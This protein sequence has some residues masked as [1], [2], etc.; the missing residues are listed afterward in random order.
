[1]TEIADCIILDDWKAAVQ[2]RFG[3][4][5]DDFSLPSDFL[6]QSRAL[7]E[8]IAKEFYGAQG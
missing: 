4:A 3:L 5:K 6:E 2:K 1:M 8:E 7:D